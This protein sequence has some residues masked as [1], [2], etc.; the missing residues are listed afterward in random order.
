M[1]LPNKYTT[2]FCI[3]FFLLKP[4]YSTLKIEGLTNYEGKNEVRIG[5]PEAAIIF[6]K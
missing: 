2:L 4:I 3:Q 5:A 6:Y 1:L